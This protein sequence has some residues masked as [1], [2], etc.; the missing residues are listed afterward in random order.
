MYLIHIEP[1]EK[2][3]ILIDVFNGIEDKMVFEFQY[4][5]YVDG[6]DQIVG[7]TMYP[8]S[9]PASTASFYIAVSKEYNVNE[10]DEDGDY[11]DSDLQ[12]LWVVLNQSN[13]N[14][15]LRGPYDCYLDFSPYRQI[16]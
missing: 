15:H 9:D 8:E 13:E 4:I 3:S 16:I 10:A 1:E 14:E 7:G 2:A 6:G 11:S 12:E 5:E